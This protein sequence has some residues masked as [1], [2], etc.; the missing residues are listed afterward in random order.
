MIFE[1]IF[2]EATRPDPLE[3]AKARVQTRVVGQII[4]ERRAMVHA[5]LKCGVPTQTA[6]A[7]CSQ[8]VAS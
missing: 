1:S 7:G 5:A 2:R 3:A 6:S 4:R 8:Q